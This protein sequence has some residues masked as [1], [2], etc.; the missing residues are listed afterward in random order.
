[1]EVQSNTLFGV[2]ANPYD[3]T[4]TAGGSSGGAAAALAARMLPIADGSDLGGS[5]RNPAAFC[6]V[7]GFRPTPG[8]VPAVPSASPFDPLQVLG[9]MGRT[10]RE[11]ALL[12]SVIA[13]M[14]LRAPLSL[15]EDA[16]PFAAPLESNPAGLRLAWSPDLGFLPVEQAVRDVAGA[17]MTHFEALGCHLE[18]ATPDLEDAAAAFQ[19]L[20]A[21]QFA[22][23]FGALID[24]RGKDFKDTIHW[25][26]RKG[27]AQ[28]PL[29]VGAKVHVDMILTLGGKKKQDSQQAWI[30]ASGKVLRTDNQG[31]AVGFDDK[32]RILPLA[33]K[34]QRPLSN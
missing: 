24:A 27:L 34:G 26:T 31:M 13:G 18:Q 10:V 14:D 19:T 15:A 6:N 23:R 5:L 22:A 29:Q 4:R 1:M 28:T 7:V 17:A 2:T 25:N 8:R 33:K 9:P 16:A 21:H 11:A 30:K 3:L 20:R 32:S 12:L